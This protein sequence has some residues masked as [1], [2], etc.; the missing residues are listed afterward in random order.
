[1][2]QKLR[3]TYEFWDVRQLQ[4]VGLTPEFATSFNYFVRDV[5][6]INTNTEGLDERITTNADNIV[7]LDVRVSDN[8]TDIFNL[9]ARVTINETDIGNLQT[10]SGDNRDRLDLLEPRVTTN[11]TDIQNNTDNL[12]THELD[13]GAHG[14]T[15]S[16]VGT[17]DYCTLVLGGVVDLAA[18]V[19]D[20]TQITTTDILAA[21]ATYDQ[22]YTQTVSDLTNENK[23]KIN[24]IVD[25][26]NEIIAGQIAA[27]QMSGV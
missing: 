17:G 23:A 26:V 18:L 21:P 3:F 10:L 14:V 5:A 6:Q 9:S 19:A 22:A 13:T 1:M 2:A 16:V 7:L 11:E 8:E 25:K 15:G 27:K 24:E 12:D 20:L 4:Q